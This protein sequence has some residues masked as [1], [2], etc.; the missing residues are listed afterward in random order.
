MHRRRHGS[1]WL[2]ITCAFND[3][4]T[5]TGR[6]CSYDIHDLRDRRLSRLYSRKLPGRHGDRSRGGLHGDG[7]LDKASRVLQHLQLAFSRGQIFQ[8][9]CLLIS[10]SICDDRIF[11]GPD[12]NKLTA[13][14]LFAGP[15]LI[16]MR[17][18]SAVLL[19]PALERRGA[20]KVTICHCLSLL[21]EQRAMID[22]DIESSFG[23]SLIAKLG[24]ALACLD[25]PI[26][27]LQSVC[28]ARA[29]L[30]RFLLASRCA[31]EPQL[32]GALR[33][34]FTRSEVIMWK[35]GFQLD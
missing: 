30:V 35:C 21:L 13:A 18:R 6:H 34:S 27:G 33:P 17:C 5:I 22:A 11:G 28:F 7:A 25:Q 15:L 2:N 1:A 14:R 8:Q 24:P 19:R 31:F 20:H 9:T 4:Q 23:E 16:T 12:L 3:Y 32:R 29:A 10:A 26:L